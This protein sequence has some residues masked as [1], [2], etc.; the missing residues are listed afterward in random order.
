[1]NAPT[2]EECEARLRKYGAAWFGEDWEGEG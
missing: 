2:K 1:M